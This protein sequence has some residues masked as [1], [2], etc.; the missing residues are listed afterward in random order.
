[1]P[2]IVNFSINA[3]DVTR[4]CHFYENVFGWKFEHMG[5][6]GF[7][8]INTGE[9]EEL[10]GMNMLHPR[11]ELKQG[12]RMTGYE[13]TISVRSLSEIVTAIR[14]QN[15]TIL[16]EETVIAG[17]GRLIF[18]EDPEGNLAVAMQYDKNAG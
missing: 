8:M 10:R 7:Y 1:M 6:P 16:M 12:V 3:D 2:N 11:R 13:C 18:F 9:T 15:G 14:A 4:A 5:P 17:T